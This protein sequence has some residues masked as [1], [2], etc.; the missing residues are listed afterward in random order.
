MEA[1]GCEG[2]SPENIDVDLNIGSKNKKIQLHLKRN[3]KINADA[4]V[5]VPRVDSKT[6]KSVLE[7][8]SIPFNAVSG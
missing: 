6:G 2:K 1:P 4:I 3:D 5:F 8:E 7:R